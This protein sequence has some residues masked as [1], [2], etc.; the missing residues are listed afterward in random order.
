MFQL[1]LDQCHRRQNRNHERHLV[2]HCLFDNFRFTN[3]ENYSCNTVACNCNSHWVYDQNWFPSNCFDFELP[4][5]SE[6]VKV[7]DGSD[8]TFLVFVSWD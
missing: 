7:F 4:K 2:G 5:L 3:T 8:L 1:T 6:R